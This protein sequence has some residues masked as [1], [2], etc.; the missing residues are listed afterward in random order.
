MKMFYTPPQIETYKSKFTQLDTTI[1][2]V[3][4]DLGR[5]VWYQLDFHSCRS[6]TY[7]AISIKQVH[8]FKSSDFS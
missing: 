5:P 4:T 1:F 3:V 2:K 6:G 7:C 8:E